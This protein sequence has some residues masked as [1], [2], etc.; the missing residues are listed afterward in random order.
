MQGSISRVTELFDGNSKHLWIP[1]YQRNYDWKLKHCARLFDDLIDIIREDRKTHFFGAIVGNPETSF[2]YVVIDGQQRLTTTSLLM[3]AL[4]HA[5]DDGIT[6]SQDPNLASDIRDSYLVL[7]ARNDAV[8][9]KLKPV[10]NDND[11][12]SRLLRGDTLIETSAI[13]AN[14]RYFRQRIAE[15]ELDGDQ[16]W[17]A[18]FRLQVMALDL[19]QQDDPQRIF[20]SINSTGLELSEADKIR[21]VVLMHQPSHEQEDLYENYWNRVEKA[22]EYRTDWFIRFYLVSKTG[23]TPRQDGVYE[24]FREYQKNSVS[25][26]REILS[27]MRDYA[28]YSHEL[29]NACTGIAHADS[30]LRRFN[31]VKHDVTLPLTMPLLGEVKTGAVS[32]EDFT[33]VIA[34]LDSYLFRRFISGVLTSAL[35]KIFAT[36]YSEIHRLRGEGDRFSDVL[37]YS[38]R[39]RA[40]SGRFPTDAEFKESFATRNLYNINRENRNYLF[41]CLENNWSNDTHDIAGALESQS[42]SIEHIMPQTLTAAWRHDLGVDADAIHATWC[43]R[44]GNLTV[45]GYNSS[46]SNSTF[47]E[48]KKRDNGFDDSPYRLNSLLKNS[49]VWTEAQLKERTQAL[50]DVALAYWPL[51]STVFEPYVPPLPS[52]PMGDDESFTNRTIVSFEFGDANKTVTSWKDAF[53]EVI[54][55]LVD[56]RREE[57]FAYSG[58]S[59]DFAIAE[60]PN[61]IS[62]RDSLVVPGLTVVTATSTRAKLAVLRKL[63]DHLDVDTDDLVFTLRNT[64]AAEPEDETTEASPFAELIKFLPK[65]EELAS[66]AVT[67]EDTRH[68]RDEFTQAFAAFTISNP[69]AT[70]PG[71]NL[72]HLESADFIEAAT[73]DEVLAALSMMLQIETMMPQFHR[74]IAAGTTVKWLTTLTSNG[75]H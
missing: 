66:T 3:L 44:I 49:D 12:Y 6:S 2:K 68:L 55:T 9:F 57:I 65:M 48:K 30:R 62:P 15:G 21:N 46:Y 45:T 71:K 35:N 33:R 32:P 22:V 63:F 50:T 23:K 31:M 27:E 56:L 40:A 4:V 41:E 69:Q 52:L 16:I 5:L 59:S 42:I 29:N 37:A 67:E 74:L 26:T 19:E 28:D 1:V 17:T 8:K 47:A 39:R 73:T 11:A 18:I 61:E 10:K 13:T 54:R 64:D 53:V 58:E 60:Y 70:I 75:V 72:T 25:T 36:L 20:E 38:L 43:N 51:P 14:Y 34:I 24:A 7:K